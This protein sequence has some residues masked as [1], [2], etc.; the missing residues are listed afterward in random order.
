MRYRRIL[1]FF[2]IA[3]L[4][5]TALLVLLLTTGTDPKVGSVTRPES[6]YEINALN[7]ADISAVA[8]KN[9][10]GTYGFIIGPDGTTTLVSEPEIPDADYSQEEMQAFIFILSKLTA[11][12][13]VD[14]KGRLAEFGLEDPQARVS[15]I[16]RDSRTL[17]FSLG[18]K[19]PVNE[20]YYFMKEGDERVFLIGKVTADLM[21]RSRTDY[22][23][24]QLVPKIA[25][26][27][28]EALKS[29]SLSAKTG[30]AHG[31][32][33]EHEGEF[34]FTLAEP[35][36]VPLK[37]DTVFSM[38]VLPLS[39]F[40]PQSFV[41]LSDDLSTYGLDTP[42]FRLTV[43]YA[44]GTI[45]LLFSQDGKGGYYAAKAGSPAVFQVSEEGADFLSVTY[46]DLL[47]DYIYNGDISTVESIEF[48][49][50]SARVPLKL[51]ILGNDGQGYGI[52]NGI[53]VPGDRLAQAVE[54]IY[55]IGITGELGQDSAL[56]EEARK[57]AEKPPQATVRIRKRNGTTDIL[58]FLP[59][60]ETRSFVR[61]NGKINFTAY[62]Q[63]AGAIETALAALGPILASQ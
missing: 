33:L 3:L 8:V 22:W 25:T 31:W 17:R 57:A 54:P 32:R 15:L 59:L 34:S 40:Y 38:I 23:N 29:I 20:G 10:T 43:E 12:Q 30:A 16:L 39:S 2:S 56:R 60:N 24:R 26:E 21:L 51:S 53:S 14:A 45:T 5:S 61:V 58:D 41:S 49:G 55:R 62:P 36:A 37:A 50:K 27:S 42:D 35:A 6:V 4:V 44:D 13:A 19:S 52:M 11:T 7:V 46:R 63:A 18:N 47:G 9:R 1:V 28:I 48:T